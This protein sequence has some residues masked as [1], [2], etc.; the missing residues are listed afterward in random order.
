MSE[1]AELRVGRR[2]VAISSPERPMFGRAGIDKLALADYYASVAEWIL[3]HLRERPIHVRVYREGIEGK[4]FVQKA[5]PGHYPEWIERARLAKR[6][7]GE[8]E[9]VVATEAATLAYLVGQNAISLHGWLALRDRPENPDQMIIDLDP[10]GDDFGEVRG[11]ARIVREVLDELGLPAYLKTTGSRGLHLT[12]PLDRSASFEETGEL[13]RGVA[14]V[15]A[16]IAPERLTDEVRKPKRHGRL[17][18]DW[19]R[20]GYAQ[21]AVVPYSVRARPGAPVAMPIHWRELGSVG[22]RD[23]TVENARRRLARVSDP[24]EGMRRRARGLERP[25]RRLQRL[26]EP[27]S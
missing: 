26:L 27:G 2:T 22:P 4:G 18:V 6:G 10:T 9:Q 20:N 7:D 15:A 5:V 16:R 3:P 1:P 8:I 14:A 21:T 12:T 11:A 13:A 25:R 19:L 23:Y 17:F 24:W